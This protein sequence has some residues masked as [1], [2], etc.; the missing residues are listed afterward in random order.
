[1]LP[2]ATSVR[3]RARPTG[4]R[5]NRRLYSGNVVFVFDDR[6]PSSGGV[7]PNSLSL[8]RR[9][10]AAGSLHNPKSA[11]L[12]PLPIAISGKASLLTFATSRRRGRDTVSFSL[13]RSLA[14]RIP[15]H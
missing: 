13:S 11:R 6:S 5:E 14:R 7:A 8:E 10:G 4:E 9:E 2:S 12:L 3:P 15:S 1:M